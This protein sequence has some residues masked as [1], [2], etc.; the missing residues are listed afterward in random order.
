[1]TGHRGHEQQLWLIRRFPERDHTAE[2][3]LPYDAFGGRQAEARLGIGAGS[4][5]EKLTRRRQGAAARH[6]AQGIEGILAGQLC[7]I[8]K[9][10]G[11]HKHHAVG[12]AHLVH[13]AGSPWISPRR[14]LPH[15]FVTHPSQTR[16]PGTGLRACHARVVD[17]T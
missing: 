10:P 7:R 14:T 5:L 9:H 16:E 12:I 4:P 15:S 11:R 3:P 6:V 2:R 8:G 1:M 17:R 13:H